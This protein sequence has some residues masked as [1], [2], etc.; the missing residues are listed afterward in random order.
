VR[1][2]QFVIADREGMICFWSAGAETAF[3]HPAAEAVGQTLD[4][5]VPP[6]FREAHWKGF[7]RAVQSS[8][9]HLEGQVTPF[10]VCCADG[11][12]LA[13]PGRLTLVRDPEGEVIAVTVAFGSDPRSAEAR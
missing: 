7:R 12:V 9:A 5:I 11:G 2:A 10:P 4:L 1:K 13:A 8:A 3:G 6:E